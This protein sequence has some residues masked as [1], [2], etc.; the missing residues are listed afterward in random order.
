MENGVWGIE[1]EVWPCIRS[2]SGK[3]ELTYQD[4]AGGKNLTVLMSI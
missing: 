4:S 2:A 3:F 1:N